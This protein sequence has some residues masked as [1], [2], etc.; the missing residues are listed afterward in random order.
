[1][2]YLHDYYKLNISLLPFNLINSCF[3]KS[4]FIMNSYFQHKLLAYKKYTSTLYILYIL[5]LISHR[6][7]YNIHCDYYDLNI[8]FN[9]N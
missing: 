2:D 6:S 4:N 8:V 9:I 5:F 7:T 1:M 3:C